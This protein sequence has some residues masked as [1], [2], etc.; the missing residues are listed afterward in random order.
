MFITRERQCTVFIVCARTMGSVL[1]IRPGVKTTKQDVL[2]L[3][4]TFSPSFIHIF[5]PLF[6]HCSDSGVLA[7]GGGGYDST[8]VR[9]YKYKCTHTSRDGRAPVHWILHTRAPYMSIPEGRATA[10]GLRNEIAST[11][12]LRSEWRQSFSPSSRTIEM[13]QRRRHSRFHG[14]I[15]TRRVT[16]GQGRSLKKNA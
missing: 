16:R 14:R 2:W 3:G 6:S 13:P 10:C 9:P 5:F 8:H 15:P 4:L 11:R 7:R 1:R 12:R